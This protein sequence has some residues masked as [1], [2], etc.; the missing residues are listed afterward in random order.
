MPIGIPATPRVPPGLV[1]VL[2]V[3]LTLPVRAE[4]DPS[5]LLSG[6]S[7]DLARYFPTYLA[8]GYVSTLS[9]PRGTE[10]NPAYLVAFMGYTPDE[11]YFGRNDGALALAA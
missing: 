5:F 4:Q 1:A 3:A 11:V 9:A 10:G 7:N 8:N 2:L 6:T